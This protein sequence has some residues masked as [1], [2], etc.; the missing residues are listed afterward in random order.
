MTAAQRAETEAVLV[1]QAR[2]AEPHQ[3]RIL[4]NQLRHQLDAD[5]VQREERYQIDTRELSL[6]TGCGGMMLIK[7]RLDKEPSRNSRPRWNLWPKPAP[8]RTASPTRAMR[9]NAPRMRSPGWPHPPDP[10]EARNTNHSSQNAGGRQPR[11]PAPKVDCHLSAAR[12]MA[13]RIR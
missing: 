3:V 12:L 4:G 10:S 6:A 5:G 8:R 11:P 7:G 9:V 13:S 2:I 1:R